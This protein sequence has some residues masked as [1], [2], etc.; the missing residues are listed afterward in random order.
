MLSYQ[1]PRSQNTVP[2]LAPYLPRDFPSGVQMLPSQYK[3]P[4]RF[5]PRHPQ[6][7]TES[8]LGIEEPWHADVELGEGPGGPGPRGGCQK[9]T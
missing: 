9:Q 4:I 3:I 6:L 5:F 1:E 2:P 7:C 8:K